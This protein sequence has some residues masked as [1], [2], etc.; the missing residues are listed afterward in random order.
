MFGLIPRREKM[1]AGYPMNLRDEF[2]ALYD[3]FFNDWP[4][5][6]GPRLEP[7][8]FWDLD[9]KDVEKEVVVRAEIPGF[10][11]AELDLELRN[12]WL[13]IKAE[14][15]YEKKE[16]EKTHEYAERRYERFVELP[17]AIDAAK[18]EAM[19]RNGVLEVHLPKTEEAIGTHIPV[20]KG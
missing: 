12:N 8:R 17:A 10:E 2:K 19:Y 1:R 16:K 15:K 6:I 11:P 9:V 3:R 7:E 4:M 5:G 20:V 14:K 13:I 18:V